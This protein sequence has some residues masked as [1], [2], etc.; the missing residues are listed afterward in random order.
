MEIPGDLKG[1]NQGKQETNLKSPA[2]E[3]NQ[4]DSQDL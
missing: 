1:K 3:T 4:M 2:G